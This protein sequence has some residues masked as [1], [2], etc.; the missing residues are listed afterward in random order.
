MLGAKV[1]TASVDDAT[2]DDAAVAADAAADD[3]GAVAAAAGDAAT[4]DAEADVED[5]SDAPKNSK[6]V[7]FIALLHCLIHCC[8]CI[9]LVSSAFFLSNKYKDNLN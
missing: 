4:I 5:A 8:T 1:E 6:S 3:A 7:A 9:G 2:A